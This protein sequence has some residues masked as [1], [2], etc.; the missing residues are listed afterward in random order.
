MPTLSGTTDDE[1]LQEVSER[2]ASAAAKLLTCTEN[3][4]ELVEGLLFGHRLGHPVGLNHDLSLTEQHGPVRGV[5]RKHHLK[6]VK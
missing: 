6:V 2:R 4:L 1:R 3:T 5:E